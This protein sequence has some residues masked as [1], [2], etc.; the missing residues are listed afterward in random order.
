MPFLID[1][2]N[3]I[4]ALPDIN[5]EDPE[6]EVALILKLRSWLGRQR[7]K[8]TVVFD[9]GIPGGYSR[10]LSSGDLEVVFAA[11]KR[12]N[13]D[14]IIMQ[15][16]EK[17]RDA[18]NWTVV[19]SDR[20]IL[21]FARRIGARGVSSQ[22]F[23]VELQPI[24]R[25]SAEKPHEPSPSEVNAWL[26][27]F[28]EPP[29]RPGRPPSSALKPSPATASP[30]VTTRTTSIRKTS[31]PKEG[32]V[33]SSPYSPTLAEQV[34]VTLVVSPDPPA[35]GLAGKPE[36]V[37]PEEVD[38]WLEVFHDMP[39]G[40]HPPRRLPKVELRPNVPGSLTVDKE[41][42]EGLA[43][44]DVNAWM[45]VFPEMEAAQSIPGDSEHTDMA[46][47][48]RQR[49]PK[50][51]RAPKLRKHQVLTP[52]LPEGTNTADGLSPEEREQWFRLYGEE[53]E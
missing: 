29:D 31:R 13:A 4:A 43:P 40:P 5:L 38:A 45:T 47:V 21:D 25:P 17:I 39:E 50:A 30:S 53:P 1:G 2:H 35:N 19:S 15:R 11:Y 41:A 23:A 9:G 6:D 12:S 26:E 42:E 44:E 16:L 10:T 24:V 20:E 7:R 46:K 37:S 14:R 28:P 36:N 8:A 49:R 52:A 3:L 18:G 48:T 33:V 22:D 51:F 27:I 32:A 34:G